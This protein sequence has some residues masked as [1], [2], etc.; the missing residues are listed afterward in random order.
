[1]A[2]RQILGQQAGLLA[3]AMLLLVEEPAR[4]QA[5]MTH[6]PV[7]GVRPD[8]GHLALA[9]LDEHPIEALNDAGHAAGPVA[10][11]LSDSIDILRSEDVGTPFSRLIVGVDQIG[12]HAL[13][14]A[15]HK[16]APRQR[17]GG[18]NDHGRVAD[19]HPQAGKDRPELVSPKRGESETNRVQ[20][21]WQI[22]KLTV[23]NR[24]AF[25]R[26]QSVNLSICQFVNF[27][28]SSL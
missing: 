7:I 5:Q 3:R 17:H 28:S 16:A 19:H 10:K 25:Q 14:Q 8:Y 21:H 23:E 13:D 12:S 20:E 24:P 15:E 18:H 4:Y 26:I 1:E 27:F 9:T 2:L 22:D 11:L 6:H